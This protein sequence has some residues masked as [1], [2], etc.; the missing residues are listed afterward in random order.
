MLPSEPHD[1]V[2]LAVHT[3]DPGIEIFVIDAA[4]QLAARGVG[5][6]DTALKPGLYT[7]RVQAGSEAHDE[8]VVLRLGAPPAEVV[9]PALRFTS[10]IPLPNTAKTHE[11][12]V[13]AAME[14]SA[15]RHVQAG[16][17]S[18]IYLFV[19]DWSS[20]S[21]SKTRRRELHPARSL[22]LR[23]LNGESI[24]DFAL[25][26]VSNITERDP[27]AATNV[28]VNPGLYVLSLELPSASRLEQT[29][30]ASPGWQTQVFML[31]R[32]YGKDPEDRYA[33]LPGASIVLSRYPVAPDP[34][35][36]DKRLVELARIALAQ[37]RR[38]LSDEIRQMLYE[39]Y[40]NP[41]LG[42]FGA[43]LL[44]LEDKPDLQLLQVVVASL[45]GLIGL[46]PDVEALA[47]SLEDDHSSY[48]FQ[49]PPMLR[50]SWAQIISATI[51]KPEIVPAG[52][53]AARVSGRLWGGEVWLQWLNPDGQI[54]THEERQM[55][56]T[57]GIKHP[58]STEERLVAQLG[59]LKT[60]L[61]STSV[62]HAMQ[63]MPDF[64]EQHAGEASE[65]PQDVP[66]DEE[67]I[68]LLVQT[69]G[70]PRAVVEERANEL[71]NLTESS[72]SQRD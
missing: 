47:L 38:A 36:Y 19:R 70:L 44:L 69:L 8:H 60:G 59:L 29:I 27:W 13:A 40:E 39:K 14:H 56:P 49:I 32:A 26:G 5:K 30:V 37:E 18:A 33:D 31:Q 64:P 20:D 53:L 43:H 66:L 23:D 25:T 11:Y 52:S 45:R 21:E 48:V 62:S 35:Y 22:E 55:S 1:L 6:L 54:D 58:S 4:F 71:R 7:V 17:G 61:S 3:Q 15:E 34:S 46:H 24:V 67:M 16:T 65:K 72:E 42:I 63:S 10:P 57:K 28:E 41:M 9:M 68:A 2:S 12:H 51:S 50:H